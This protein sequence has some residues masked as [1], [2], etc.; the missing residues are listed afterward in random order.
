VAIRDRDFLMRVRLR[1]GWGVGG[2]ICIGIDIDIWSGTGIVSVAG[3]VAAASGA[4]A[5][6]FWP[7]FG[8]VAVVRI[9]EVDDEGIFVGMAGV[10]IL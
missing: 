10:D 5:S 9:T 6:S 4:G 2:C 3:I 1:D 8:S 7:N